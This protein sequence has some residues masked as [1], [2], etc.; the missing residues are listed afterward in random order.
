M[1]K[2][3]FKIIMTFAAA[4]LVCLIYSGKAEAAV[5]TMPDGG[6]FD[7]SFY[8][9]TYDDVYK[10]FGM[11]E[12]LLYQHYLLCGMKERRLPYAGY[13]YP[14]VP[15]QSVSGSD[16]KT[17]LRMPDGTLFDP[18][19]YVKKYP[20]VVAI[21]GTD[22]M[23]LYAH[24]VYYGMAEGRL[25]YEGYQA[26][27]LKLTF[28]TTGAIADCYSVDDIISGVRQAAKYRVTNLKIYDHWSSG[29]S[30]ET[31][32]VLVT[33]Q[34]GYVQ[35]VYGVKKITCSKTLIYGDVTNLIIETDVTLKY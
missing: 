35:N 12:A 16:S 7:P 15:T 27:Q 32:P 25:P 33:G 5:K 29:V 2:N 18:E 26:S 13:V 20:D 34:L 9:A 17:V 23:L 24:Y 31:L 21:F 10:A 3:I 4:A 8:A 28:S 22:P 14:T 6:L 11:N 1:K 30:A 19:F